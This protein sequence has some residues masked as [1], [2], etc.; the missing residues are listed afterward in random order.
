MEGITLR[1]V[2]CLVCALF[3]IVSGRMLNRQ[4]VTLYFSSPRLE[5]SYP[6]LLETFLRAE[7][8]VF[9]V[10]LEAGR[11]LQSSRFVLAIGPE[12]L[13]L[14]RRFRG[15]NRHSLCRNRYRTWD[16]DKHGSFL[17]EDSSTR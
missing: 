14:R 7:V 9:Y 17:A 12:A 2:H 13:F 6:V 16:N 10:E 5:D 8:A 15:H 3:A 11:T 1:F 4:S